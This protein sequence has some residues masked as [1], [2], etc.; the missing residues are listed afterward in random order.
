MAVS[1]TQIINKVSILLQDT[2]ASRWT[3]AE[4]LGW[5]NLG[6][7]QIGTAKPDAIA[8][9]T[10]MK[11]TPGKTKQSL[12][13]GSSAYQDANGVTLRAGIKLFDIVRNMGSTGLVPG[14]A[15]SVTD[16]QL[17]D[18]FNSDWHDVTPAAAV[19][20]YTYDEKTPK[21]FYVYPAAHKT[22]PVWVEVTYAALPPILTAEQNI[23]LPDEYEAILMDYILFRAYSK[24]TDSPGAF[25][26]ALAYYEAYLRALDRYAM[27]EFE[28]DPNKAAT[29]KPS[30]SYK[31]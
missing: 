30:P 1:A 5:L 10:E 29:I 3:V 2:S 31:R 19:A 9:T 21:V 7:V 22:T 6:Q 13:D 17:L 11:L 14:R 12:P 18:Q 26:K 4:L 25:Q 15:I 8:V 24:E 23:V 28:F 20:N 16:R 27:T